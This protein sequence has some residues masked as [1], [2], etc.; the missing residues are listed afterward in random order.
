MIARKAAQ[1]FTLV[2]VAIVTVIAGLL[3]GGVLKGQELVN[4]ARAK[5]LINDLNGVQAA[6]LAY[7]DRYNTW[8]G[9]DQT[10]ADRWGPTFSAASGNGTGQIDG[11]YH[12]MTTPAESADPTLLTTAA[13]TTGV[14]ES[15]VF[16]WHMRI[17]GFVYGPVS[18]PGAADLPVTAAGGILG[19]QG[20][21]VAGFMS[22]IL[23]CA[24]DV[25]D[26]SA[27]AVDGQIDDLRP[28]LGIVQ[29]LEQ[30]TGAGL[31]SLATL[32]TARARIP[33]YVE[34]QAGRYTVCRQL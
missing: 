11:G 16:W 6:V 12:E 31:Q 3:V 28:M 9:D 13:R 24:N 27:I 19:I 8:P 7:R 34:G 33:D 25:A 2:E 18:G 1:G 5:S 29:A 4:Q 17:A 26:K 15:K 30:T 14:G 21:P 22:G 23:A 20:L 10:A 32:L